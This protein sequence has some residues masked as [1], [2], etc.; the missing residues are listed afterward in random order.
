MK[1]CYEEAWNMNDM[2]RRLAQRQDELDWLYMELYND[3]ARLDELKAKMAQA[4]RDRGQGLRRLD[5]KREAEPEWFRAGN[6][7]G[8]T[9][10]PGLFA[11]NLRGVEEKLGYLKE[12][13]ITYVHLMPLLKMPHPDNDGGYAV[14][15]FDRVEPALGTNEDLSHLAAAM[16]RRG[17]S[18]CLDFVINHTADTHEWAKRARA[19][20]QEY[21]DRYICFDTPEIPREMEKA[22]PDV[23]PETAPGSF[24]YQEQMRKYV[25]SSF[26]PYQWDLNYRN[27]VVFNEMVG[28][29]L[30]LANL[31]VEVLRIDAVPYLWKE[32]GTTCR[33]LPQVHTI[34]RMIRLIIECV[35]PGVILKGEVVM[36]PKEL[37]P[38]FGT[39]EKPEC[40]LLY[41]ASTM[42]AQWS[43]L[44]SGDV[45][46]LKRQL[47]DLH[48]LPAHCWF[49]NYLRCHD[50]IGWGLNE[51]YGR[52]LGIDPVAHKKFLY[53]FFEGSFPGSYARGERYNYNPV[54]QD[55]RTCGTTASLC[56]IEKGLL[57]ED[58]E[59]VSQGIQRDLMMHAVIMCM[60][61]FPM[62]SSGDEIGQLNGY[63]YHDDP[64]LREDSRNL[65]RTPFNWGDAAKRT[66][67][68]TVQQRIW[69]G[70]R[71][72]EQ[73]RAAQPC[74]GPTA[75][76]TTWD[77]HNDHVLAIVR[78]TQE[79]TLVGLFNFSGAEQEVRL[80]AMEGEFTDL[81]SGSRCVCGHCTVAPYQYAIM[82]RVAF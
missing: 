33:N 13:G 78:R 10:Y 75:W 66:Q 17:M 54:T 60:G 4:Y 68:G 6:M 43:A 15:D 73:L 46:Q 71:Q 65:H 16:R 5:R 11:G 39:A 52:T 42:A 79:E 49:V 41:N 23:F 59:Q 80:D 81:I 29:M 48:S 36:A 61:G 3:R 26:H 67:A 51:E 74:F 7:L 8:I 40:H 34:V 14:E 38:Y 45:R 44:A 62:L 57:E 58:G 30:H 24:I 20:E 47:D 35:C 1:R 19:G 53:E 9:M 50:D 63:G 2:E 21:I 76:V 64:V 77:T 70:L 12:Q 31:G 82:C 56:G 28:S 72:L 18:L 25:C 69:D 27:P 37:A 32:I 55:A 22:V